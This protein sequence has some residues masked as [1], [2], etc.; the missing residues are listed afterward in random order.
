MRCHSSRRAAI[1]CE[2]QTRRLLFYPMRMLLFKS[3]PLHTSQKAGASADTGHGEPAVSHSSI[4]DEFLFQ[5][6][7]D[8]IVPRG[9]TK[10]SHPIFRDRLS[11]CLD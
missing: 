7:R 6:P 1:S 4:A 11:L 9:F 3:P 2:P 10:H 8:G 5:I